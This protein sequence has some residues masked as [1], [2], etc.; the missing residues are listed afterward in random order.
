M[1]G[2]DSHF[3]Q[4]LPHSLLLTARQ[5]ICAY[6][7]SNIVTVRMRCLQRSVHQAGTV[8][9][10]TIHT[11]APAF[12]ASFAAPTHQ[13]GRCCGAQNFQPVCHS[14]PIEGHMFG[15]LVI[16]SR[17]C[18]ACT[19]VKTV[20][21]GQQ[22]SGAPS[23]ATSATAGRCACYRYHHPIPAAR[24]CMLHLPSAARE[25]RRPRNTLRRPA[26]GCSAGAP[27]LPLVIPRYRF[28]SSVQPLF[29]AAA[30][31]HRCYLLRE[32]FSPPSLAS[33][34]FLPFSHGGIT[35]PPYRRRR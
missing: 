28:G 29:Y 26:S 34:L 6:C 9:S 19:L 12:G 16:L 17:R 35:L 10:S 23:F 1:A 7:V 24:P 31:Y 11:G 4:L 30:C 32:E 8:I 22:R 15:R 14:G 13:L 5:T 25:G 2:R 20:P 33:S 18:R 27:G 21:G 3:S